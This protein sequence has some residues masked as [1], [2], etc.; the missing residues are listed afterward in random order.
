[1]DND[2]SMEHGHADDEESML[3]EASVTNNN[4]PMTDVESEETKDDSNDQVSVSENPATPSKDKEDGTVDSHTPPHSDKKKTPKNGIS[5]TTTEKDGGSGMADAS[6]PVSGAETAQA[7]T[8]KHEH[9]NPSTSSTVG[10]VRNDRNGTTSRSRAT[11]ESSDDGFVV[12]TVSTTTTNPIRNSKSV[13]PKETRSVLQT[14]TT[15]TPPTKKTSSTLSA[16]ALAAIA[17]AQQEAEMM[18]QQQQQTAATTSTVNEPDGDGSN[19]DGKKKKSKKKKK[20]HDPEKFEKREK[21]K[22]KKR[23][24]EKREK[25]TKHT[26]EDLVVE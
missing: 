10:E 1:M 19:K 13:P 12:N 23:E 26:P 6:L 18:L 5:N 17:A 25:K 14:K 11:S 4:T 9:Q 20:E 21:K 3:K 15:D 7:L 16:A 24:K 8:T 22:K 2:T